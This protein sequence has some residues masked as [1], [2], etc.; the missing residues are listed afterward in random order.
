[1]KQIQYQD[2]SPEECVHPL[3]CNLTV[4]F[5]QYTH[6]HTHTHTLFL[7][8]ASPDHSTSTPVCSNQCCVTDTH[9]CVCARAC[10]TGRQC[11]HFINTCFFPTRFT[12]LQSLCLSCPLTPKMP[13]WLWCDES[14]QWISHWSSHTQAWITGLWWVLQS[15]LSLSSLTAL[16]PVSPQ[17]LLL[18]QQF[19]TVWIVDIAVDRFCGTWMPIGPL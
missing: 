14:W 17:T 19:Y 18:Y 8:Q 6:T 15:A 2:K 3:S 7:K 4:T 1:M 12:S 5:L 13:P 10:V 9:R 16:A 11:R